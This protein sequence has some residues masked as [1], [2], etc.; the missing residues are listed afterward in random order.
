MIH[1][2]SP[3]YFDI[4]GHIFAQK[5]SIKNGIQKDTVCGW[6]ERDY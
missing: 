3:L 5:S 1:F 4:L 6:F 2:L